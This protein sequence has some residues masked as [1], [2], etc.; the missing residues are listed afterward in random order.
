M[1]H[2]SEPERIREGPSIQA[3]HRYCN[4]AT[5][6][7]LKIFVFSSAASAKDSATSAFDPEFLPQRAQ[8]LSQRSQRR[9]RTSRQDHG[10]RSTPLFPASAIGFLALGLHWSL[11]I[12]AS[13][14]L[15]S[16]QQGRIVAVRAQSQAREG[17]EGKRDGDRE[18]FSLA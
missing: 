15:P 1:G 4:S 11:A 8:S 7:Y 5:S 12:S 16:N 3:A 17:P 18:I 14:F 2:C 13:A 9:K 10:Q 6:S